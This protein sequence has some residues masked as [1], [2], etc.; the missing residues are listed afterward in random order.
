MTR[1]ALPL[2]IL[3]GL[4]GTA[5]EGG[6]TLDLE[7]LARIA[8]L[9]GSRVKP[10]DSLARELLRDISGN[11]I[12]GT[13]KEVAA[14]AARPRLESFLSLLFEPD[15]ARKT[16]LISIPYRPLA[17]ALGLPDG[18]AH[19]SASFLE[20]SRAFREI[21]ARIE[22]E[23]QGRT[24]A[25]PFDKEAA[26]VRSRLALFGRVTAVRILPVVMDPREVRTD[27]LNWREW[28]TPE[29]AGAMKLPPAVADEILTAFHTLRDAF[30]ARDGP[31]FAAASR[32]FASALRK[33]NPAL[34][35]A[36][37]S[38]DRE[39]HFNRLDPVNRSRWLYAGAAVLFVFAGVFR[40]RPLAWLALVVLSGG[41]A[42]QG[43]GLWLRLA[44]SGRALISNFYESVIFLAAVCGLAGLVMEL[45][46]R[47]TWAGLSGA[48]LAFF[49]L[50]IAA[51][52]PHELDPELA[53]L[54]PVLAN[55]FWIHIHVPTMV[56]SYA[57]YGIAGV[58][59][60]GILA[61]IAWGH[62]GGP[63]RKQAMT[64]LLRAVHVGII[65]NF[66]GMIL[67]GIWAYYSW[68]R[69]WG[70]DAKETWSLILWIFYLIMIHGHWTGSLG[71]FGRAAMAALGLGVTV[72]TYWGV[73]FLHTGLHAYAGADVDPASTWWTRYM[74][75]PDWFRFGLPALGVAILALSVVHLARGGGPRSARA[76]TPEV[77]P[78]GSAADAGE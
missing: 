16:A 6:D 31:G 24:P 34:Y 61:S 46:Y 41:L 54:L 9:H 66:A 37:V 30:V 45:V 71:D 36:D 5:R 28:G 57:L 64:Q 52:S 22:A 47:R 59:G 51:S 55:N 29:D 27:R 10:L 19:A 73:N 74:N 33:A 14:F 17:V 11:G 7:V 38:F 78:G 76:A 42:L 25:K 44:I 40:V 69:F 39:I 20:E 53:P 50:E 75:A 3:L 58:V 21:L 15:R 43:Y 4:S 49:L 70:F 48:F 8:T 12:S 23:Y 68:G 35:P 1:L 60:L 26:L 56:A 72:Y 2:A 62:R 67:G 13:K 18:Y 65:L 63:G 32:T 77:A